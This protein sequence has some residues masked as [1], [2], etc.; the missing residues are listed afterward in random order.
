MREFP[1]EAALSALRTSGV[2][3]AV[4]HEEFYGTAA[5]REV[6]RQVEQSPSLAP[7][8]TA[9]DGGFEARIYQVLR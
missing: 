9:A 8:N 7:I 1:D 4:I 6:I 2:S 3:Y 5:Y